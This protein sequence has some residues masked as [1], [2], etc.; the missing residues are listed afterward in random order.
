MFDLDSLV[1]SCHD[2]LREGEPRR[3]VRE[4][5]LRALERP[6]AVAERLGRSQGGLEILFNSPELTVLNVVWAPRMSIY[7]HDHRMWAVIGIYGGAEDNTLF[8]RSPHG[9]VRSGAKVLAEGQVLS[10]GAEAIHSVDNPLA[11]FTGAIHVYG[12]DFVNQPRSQWDSETLQE[13]P[14]DAAQVRRVFDAA[15]ASWA[16]EVSTT[17][18]RELRPDSDLSED[19]R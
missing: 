18:G 4:I 12:G 17:S 3:I 9:L 1:G 10:L 5:L 11:R 19:F 13:Q 7:P 14:Y 8:R 15:N 2:S 6:G 16:E